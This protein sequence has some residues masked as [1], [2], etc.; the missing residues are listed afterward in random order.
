MG[1]L[2]AKRLCEKE[3]GGEEVDGGLTKM[4]GQLRN[5]HQHLDTEL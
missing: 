4:M 5:H 3:G 2:G 1:R